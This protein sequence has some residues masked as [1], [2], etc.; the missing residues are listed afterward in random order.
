MI[1][2]RGYNI[3]VKQIARILLSGLLMLS[4]SFKASAQENKSIMD[5]TLG[6]LGSDKDYVYLVDLTLKVRDTL[7]SP[8]MYS[9]IWENCPLKTGRTYQAKLAY[10]PTQ[11]IHDIRSVQFN[12]EEI[13]FND[14]HVYNRIFHKETDGINRNAAPDGGHW[15]WEN[16]RA[17][18]KVGSK[19]TINWKE[20]KVEKIK[21]EKTKYVAPCNDHA[22]FSNTTLNV[23]ITIKPGGDKKWTFSEAPELVAR[24]VLLDLNGNSKNIVFKEANGVKSDF[25]FSVI[26]TESVDGTPRYSAN[27][28]LTYGAQNMSFS[29]NSGSYTFTTWGDAI[30]NLSGKMLS[31]ITLG[32]RSDPPCT[33]SDGT[34]RK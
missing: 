25:D 6:M 13:K 8:Y 26:L 32:W 28:T 22:G 24:R 33:Q 4:T 11:H 17:I 1:N 3:F 31:W 12:G 10:N 19:E 16:G 9:V 2:F 20:A 27:A 30:D 18:A 23:L 14:W 5:V 29:E 7:S 34:V 21:K 15:E